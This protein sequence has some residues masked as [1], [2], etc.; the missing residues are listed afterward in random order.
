MLRYNKY[1]LLLESKQLEKKKK[2]I[3]KKINFFC[4]IDDFNNY[5]IDKL[6]INED[7]H[8]LNFAIWIIDNIIKLTIKNTK[9][10]H[11]EIWEETIKNGSDGELKNT[12]N[13]YMKFVLD[14]A[15]RG[16]IDWIV[17]PRRTEKIN[18]KEL[19]YEIAKEKSKEWH[20][21]MKASGVVVNE[22][23]HIFMVFDDGYYWIDLGGNYCESE[24]D[25]MGHCATTN[26]DTLLSLRKNKKPHVTIAYNYD[27]PYN[28]YSE[29]TQ[30]K[31]KQNTKPDKKYH[32][33]IVELLKLNENRIKN[34]KV[35][36]SIINKGESDEYETYYEISH[37][38]S[39]YQPEDDF[40]L[41]DLDVEFTLEL[42]NANKKL[43]DGDFHALRNLWKINL[44][45]DEEIEKTKTDIF[46]HDGKLL[47]YVSDWGDFDNFGEN[48]SFKEIISGEGFENFMTNYSSF[49]YD[50]NYDFNKTVFEE[51]KKYIINKNISIDDFKLTKD[52]IYYDEKDDDLI[53]KVR[54]EKIKLKDILTDNVDSE[55]ILINFYDFEDIGEAFKMGY[56]DASNSADYSSAYETITNSIID[57]LG[58][59]EL[60]EINDEWR[61]CFNIIDTDFFEMI[62]TKDESDN[63]IDLINSD[64]WDGFKV[65]VPYYGWSGEASVYDVSE[66]ILNFLSNLD[67]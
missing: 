65:D 9:K 39:E 47:F 29:A 31:G 6:I 55:N 61:F 23:G 4:K 26:S 54:E 46:V 52:D 21:Q 20:S 37:L 5:V 28:E 60:I 11:K 56:G 67:Y 34:V 1:I 25:A 51:V 14:D 57:R 53:L 2:K 15:Y 30:I 12:I 58:E 38:G 24:A 32:K 35:N 48:K 59:F 36:S 7:V 50:Y 19:T 27:S 13:K 66:E 40:Q 45:S 17:S 33:Y 41:S 64:S 16:I 63:L 42:Y 8:N 44:I 10:V 49:D 18:I 22:D 43:Y 3:L 62:D